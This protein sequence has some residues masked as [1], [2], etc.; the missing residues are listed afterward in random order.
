MKV[1]DLKKDELI[2]DWLKSRRAA[3]NTQR[4]YLMSMQFYTDFT[5]M[6]PTELLE[7]AEAEA[8]ACVLVRKRKIKSRLINF[9][10]FLEAREVAPMT[11]KSRMN[12]VRSFYK[13]FDI[14][15]P[16]LPKSEQ[17]AQSLPQHRAIPTKEDI[18]EVL[19]ICDPLER[20][21]LLVGASSGL[22]VN[23]ITKLRVKDFME[24]YD[25][26]TGIT[27]LQLRREKTNYDFITFLTPEASKAVLNYLNYRNRKVKTNQQKRAEQL[28][29]QRVILK[30]DGK[31]AEEGYL[32]ICR[33]VPDKYLKTKD[34]SLRRLNEKTVMNRY[35]RIS[36]DAQ[37]N[38]EKG[39][40]NIIRSHNLRKWFNSRLLNAGAELFFVDFLMGHKID[41]VREAYY[42]AD[43]E[44]L[45]EIYR[46]YIPYLT[47]QKEVDISESPEYMRIKQENQI[48][49][50]ETVRH[51]VERSELQEL[52]AEMEK[53]KEKEKRE[54]NIEDEFKD[55]IQNNP[56][57]IELLIKKIKDEI[58]KV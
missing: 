50:A 31:P 25:E 15:V 39:N 43:P 3:H 4:G 12:A 20:A 2:T 10:E 38:T 9:R 16:E 48:L 55:Y 54:C 11:V 30:K 17:R 34:E 13:S 1:S 28:K 29:K 22:A 35:R 27:T 57:M 58:I 5:G 21:I 51:I 24:G 33:N 53:I 44:S 41:S 37:K 23:E 42:R 8:E 7:E 36:E 46:K 19:T 45:R 32:F 47:I 56:E 18:R 40:W 14:P 52:R 6:T 49:Q 26:E